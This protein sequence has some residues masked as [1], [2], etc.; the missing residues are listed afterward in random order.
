M[1]NHGG[2]PD[3]DAADS[4]RDRTRAARRGLDASTRRSAEEAICA[5]LT[6]L[7][8]LA[9]GATVGWYLPTDG[10]VDLAL[11]I[12]PLRARGIRLALPVL[13]PSRSMTYAAWSP[14]TV[15][16]PNRFGILEPSE[17]T[18]GP[19]APDE[20]DVAVVPCVAVDADGHRLGFGA[21]YYD[22]AFAD[23]AHVVLVGVA[24]EVQVVQHL[25][26]APWDVPLDVVVTE[27]RTLRTHAR[28]RG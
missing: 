13:G 2:H 8:E 6:A 22:R 16:A 1:S 11:A 21:G 26:S 27:T 4:P 5:Q 10:E 24:F 25:D 9:A 7:S 3:T 12:A 18:S 17:P 19:T 20:L 14:D 15:L 28:D 23:A